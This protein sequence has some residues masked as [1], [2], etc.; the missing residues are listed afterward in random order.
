MAEGLDAQK[1]FI[2][3]ALDYWWHESNSIRILITGKTGT[4]KSSLVNALLGKEVAVVGKKLDPQTSEVTMFDT[5]I[6]GIKV[7]ICDSPGL[8]DGLE[9]E[10]CYL[11]D[12]KAKCK[13]NIDLLLYCIAMD[14][15]RFLDGSRDI[16]SMVKLTNELG[17]E[18]WNNAVIVL[19]CA[20]KFLTTKKST[21]VKSDDIN[22]KLSTIF[23]EKLKMWRSCL[24]KCLKENLRLSTETIVKLPILPT[25]RRGL[26]LLLKGS[27]P[28]LSNFWMGSLLATKRAA[29]PALV[30][31]N[32]HRL[33][34]ASDIRSEEEF[35]ELLKK[36]NI[37]IKDMA[38][39][40][41]KLINADEA[42][43]KVGE[44]SGI[45]ATIAH[46]IEHMFSNDPTLTVLGTIVVVNRGNIGAYVLCMRH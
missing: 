44:L 43:R 1:G 28:W 34:N 9:N 27:K 21:L 18:I 15:P 2:T 16:E 40:I 32:L 7:I 10:E 42:A 31:M 13:E 5:E 25:G 20:N 22:E 35:E 38:S 39:E 24:I 23:D 11:K 46:L 45:K 6:E 37:I 3:D 12:I 33:K 29:Q 30:K 41:G 4:G 8:Q 17:K 26:P 36:E 14:N 19:T